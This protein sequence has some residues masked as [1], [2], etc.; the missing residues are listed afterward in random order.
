MV[1][2]RESRDSAVDVVGAMEWVSFDLRDSGGELAEVGLSSLSLVLSLVLSLLLPKPNIV[3]VGAAGLSLGVAGR[4][5]EDEVG[6]VPIGGC[7]VR[8]A[9]LGSRNSPSSSGLRDKFVWE[10]KPT[11][12]RREW[13]LE[14]ED[15]QSGTK[16]L[17]RAPGRYSQEIC[18]TEGRGST[19]NEYVEPGRGDE[20]PP[21]PLGSSWPFLGA[22]GS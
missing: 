1:R 10:P 22:N 2:S 4:C 19:S 16:G 14:I 8:T 21:L 5:W 7:D 13:L 3:K 17:F 18:S 12:G 11:E 9:R 15:D 6:R 20:L